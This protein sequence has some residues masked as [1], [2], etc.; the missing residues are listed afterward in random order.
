MIRADLDPRDYVRALRLG[1][2]VTSASTSRLLTV[3]GMES[4]FLPSLDLVPVEG[5]PLP[6]AA[7]TSHTDTPNLASFDLDWSDTNI[8][9]LLH[10]SDIMDISTYDAEEITLSD[11][12]AASYQL[13]ELSRPIGVE[14]NLVKTVCVTISRADTANMQQRGICTNQFG[15][16]RVTFSSALISSF[17]NV[18]V[19]PANGIR[20]S[21]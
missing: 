14:F 2:F 9:L 21:L 15:S 19:Q 17:V 1:I 6:A 10:F 13:T 3:D 18:P 4:D 5:T 8:L 12:A 11:G 7:F 20:V 16:C